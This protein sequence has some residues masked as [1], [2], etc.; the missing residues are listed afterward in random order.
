MTRH[1]FTA[2]GTDVE[3]ILDTAPGPAAE[4]RLAAAEADVRR[5]E[6]VFSRFRPDSEL[7]KLNRLG[8]LRPSPALAE[9][10]RLALRARDTSGGRFDPTVHDA[11]VAAGYSRSFDDLA[12][13]TVARAARVRTVCAGAVDLDDLTGEV[14]LAGGVH[15]DLGGIA[16]GWIVDRIA[17]RL[18]EAGPCLVNAGGDLAISAPRSTGA[19]PVGVA[20]GDGESITLDLG[21]GAMATSGR[22]RRRWEG[23]DGPAHHIIDPRTGAP[24]ETDLIRVTAVA[25]TA[26]EAEVLAKSLLIAGASDAADEANANDIAAVLIAEDGAVTLTG[27]L[28]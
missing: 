25:S 2:L 7:S 18:G 27:G 12:Q 22:D 26:V 11:L 19:W 16:K 1:R 24:A 28:R 14:R 20:L 15:I 10:V 13:T 8:R 17:A 23:P 6:A 4:M 5:Y 21:R 3:L 9:V